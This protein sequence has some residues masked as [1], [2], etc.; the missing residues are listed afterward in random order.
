[1]LG[2]AVVLLQADGAAGG[3]LLLKGEDVLDGGPPEAVDGLVVVAH[4]AEVLIAPSQGR[5]QQVLEVVGVLVLVDEHIPELPLVEVPHLLKLLEELGD[6]GQAV[7][8]G[9]LALGQIFLRQLH[10]V[11]GPG[12]VPQHGPGRELLVV[13]VQVLQAVLDDPDG[14]VGV[15]DGEGGGEAQPVDVP[16]QDA[17]AGGVEGGGPHVLRLGQAVLQLPGGLVGEGDG[18]NGPGGGGLQA[19]QPLLARLVLRGGGDL[20]GGVVLQKGQVVGSHPLRHLLAVRSP[21]V[22]HQIGD[23]VDEHGGLAAPRP[24]QKEEG[25]LGGQHRPEGGG[26]PR[27]PAPPSAAPGLIGKTP[28]RWPPGGP[29]KSEVLLDG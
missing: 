25:A 26:G 6:L 12:D 21:A 13:Q 28:G 18:Q 4:H 29:C 5:G 20:P 10:G 9:L 15:V 24:G 17:H 3:I 7:V 16:A 22:L 19:A 8:P 11:L 27:W 14:V 1:M 2:G 23:S